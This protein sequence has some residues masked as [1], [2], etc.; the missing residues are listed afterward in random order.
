MA[1]LERLMTVEQVCE[2][3]GVSRDTWDKWRTKGTSPK[4]RRLPNGSLR[5]SEDDLAVW[6]EEL[7]AA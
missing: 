6:V 5:V 3:L 2:Y 4:A 7:V 1:R